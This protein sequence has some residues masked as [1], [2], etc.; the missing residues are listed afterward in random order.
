MTAN[1]RPF[2]T[3][4]LLDNARREPRDYQDALAILQ[5]IKVRGRS[6]TYQVVR[7][8]AEPLWK[9]KGWLTRLGY[10]PEDLNK[11]NAIHLTGSKGKGSI[12]SYTSSLLTGIAP[13]AKVGRYTSPHLVYDRERI[14]INGE[15]ISEELF[16]K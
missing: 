9:F 3:R 1:A 10:F 14:S 16:A 6:K 7:A 11:L 2:T 4:E 12:A 15:P 8:E 5:G 13:N